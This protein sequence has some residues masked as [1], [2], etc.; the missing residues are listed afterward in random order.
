MHSFIVY[1]VAASLANLV[2]FA[3]ADHRLVYDAEGYNGGAFGRRPN[4]TYLSTKIASPLFQ[5]NSWNRTTT[6]DSKYLFLGLWNPLGGSAGPMIFSTEDFSLVYADWSWPSTHNTRVQKFKGVDYLTFYEGAQ[7][8]GHS[9]GNCLMLDSSYNVAYNITTRN[10]S[11]TVDMHE[12]EVTEDGTVLISVYESIWTNLTGVGGP[13]RGELLDSIVQ[14]I[15]IE[16]NELLFMWKAS[17]HTNVTDTYSH[18]HRS[19]G[20][21]DFFHLNSVQKTKEG[22]YLISARHFHT[23]TYVNGSTGETIWTLGGKQNDFTDISNGSATDF[24]WQHHARFR[25]DDLTQLTFFDNHALKTEIG[26]KKDCSRGRHVELNYDDMTVRLVQD[27]FHPTS[28]TSTAR[29]GYTVVPNGNVL[30]SWGV[31]PAFTEY[32]PDGECVQDV[33]F[34]LWDPKAEGRGH[35]RAFKMDWVGKPSWDPSIASVIEPYG[36]SKVAVSW[37]GATEIASWELYT[38]DTQTTVTELSHT[39][40]KTGFET[41]MVIGPG[42]KY[43]RATALDKDGHVLGKTPVIDLWSGETTPVIEIPAS[44][45]VSDFLSGFYLYFLRIISFYR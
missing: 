39:I 15:D 2:Q 32:T 33:Q 26:C 37:N 4:Q 42:P 19:E 44:V 5:I 40:K 45:A 23:L 43:A 7:K 1:T 13:Q 9:S 36:G 25:D 41:I 8:D 38:G 17:E 11:S 22:N 27:Y 34:D 24:G 12:C 28:L 31:N 21:W 3:A 20:G 14:E 29:G 6:D 16:T 10:V 35:Y 18:Y 30:I